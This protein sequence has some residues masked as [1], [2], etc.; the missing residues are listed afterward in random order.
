MTTYL[1]ITSDK[2]TELT[3]FVAPKKP[4]RD[5][6]GQIWEYSADN[7]RWYEEIE[8]AKA[9]RLPVVNPED[10]LWRCIDGHQLNEFSDSVIKLDTP[11]E[12]EGWEP[13][14]VYQEAYL[15]GEGEIW[16]KC[17]IDRF[18][19]IRHLDCKRQ[20]YRLKRSE[21]VKELP[22]ECQDPIASIGGCVFG[23]SSK[24]YCKK[25]VNEY[26][27]EAK[28]QEHCGGRNCPPFEYACANGCMNPVATESHKTH[29]S[30]T[31]LWNDLLEDVDRFSYSEKLA[32]NE[33]PKKWILTRRNP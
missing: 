12:L 10:A 31:E 22:E 19:N 16:K 5:H 8:T 21:P 3:A 11:V 30:Q 13:E 29:E 9:S 23:G 2:P 4:L 1:L 18:N 20:A 26:P 14:I 6:Y 33:L 27:I 24:N 32:V 7:T 25:C 28:T 17:S 15:S